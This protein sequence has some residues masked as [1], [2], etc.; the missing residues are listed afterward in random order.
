MIFTFQNT[1]DANLAVF[2]QNN[3]ILSRAISPAEIRFVPIQTADQAG[4]QLLTNFND[5]PGSDSTFSSSHIVQFSYAGQAA[6]G[7]VI[8]AQ[9]LSMDA[10]AHGDPLSTAFIQILDFQQY[11]NSGFLATETGIRNEQNITVFDQH[12]DNVL[13]EVPGLL[14]TESSVSAFTTQISAFSTA[15]ASTALNSAT[16]LYTTGPFAPP[17]SL[18][19]FTYVNIDLPGTDTTSASGLTN[20]G[21]VIGSYR[22]NAGKIHGYVM[23]PQGTFTNIWRRIERPRGCCRSIY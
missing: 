11:P 21:R 7:A 1:F 12:S 3:V 18:G 14:S 8:R 2:D 13:L 10:A 5:G 17:P 6:S 20:S 23:E 22:D 19:A 16:F 15:F 4:F 9:G